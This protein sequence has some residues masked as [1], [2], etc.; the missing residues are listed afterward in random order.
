MLSNMLDETL[1]VSQVGDTQNATGMVGGNTK[2]FTSRLSDVPCSHKV[3]VGTNWTERNDYGKRSDFVMHR[4]YLE[5]TAANRA[6]I[7]S[8]RITFDSDTYE[9]KSINN[10]AGKN[11]LL[12]IDALKVE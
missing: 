4:F 6:I 7:T 11:R 5:A 1:D 12:Q 8:D 10:V 3:R 9:I 2:A